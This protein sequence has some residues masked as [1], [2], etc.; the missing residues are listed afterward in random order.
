MDGSPTYIHDL[1]LGERNPS[2]PC[3]E[4]T[5]LD[6]GRLPSGAG[7]MLAKRSDLD[8][9]V[10]LGFTSEGFTV[11]SGSQT[12]GV[13]V[14]TL[15]PGALEDPRASFEGMLWEHLATSLRVVDPQDGPV[16]FIRTKTTVYRVP[17]RVGRFVRCTGPRFTPWRTPPTGLLVV[18]TRSVVFIPGHVYHVDPPVPPPPITGQGT[19]TALR[20]GDRG[21]YVG[22]WSPRQGVT[23]LFA[24][25]GRGGQG[26]L[27]SDARWL[28]RDNDE[29]TPALLEHY[30][31]LVR[32]LVAAP[33]GEAV[34]L[35]L[36]DDGVVVPHGT[37][38][39][40]LGVQPIVLLRPL[41]TCDGTASD[42][43]TFDS[44]VRMTGV[45]APSTAAV[46]AEWP[47]FFDAPHTLIPFDEDFDRG[48]IEGAVQLYHSVR[49]DREVL[50]DHPAEWLLGAVTHALTYSVT[51]GDPPQAD[52]VKLAKAPDPVRLVRAWLEAA[53]AVSSRDAAVVA[54]A[55]Y[56][57][58]CLH[59]R[60][61]DRL[62]GDAA[63]ILMASALHLV[64]ASAAT[65]RLEDAD[66]AS[67]RRHEAWLR[68]NLGN[69][70][71]ALGVSV[72]A[73]STEHFVKDPLAALAD[74]DE[75][76][77]RVRAL[78]CHAMI[79]A[80]VV[81]STSVSG[82]RVFALRP[83]FVVALDAPSVGALESAARQ[84]AWLGDKKSVDMLDRWANKNGYLQ[85]GLL[86]WKKR[87]VS[88]LAEHWHRVAAWLRASRTRPAETT[89]RLIEAHTR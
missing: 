51:R 6:I 67:Q 30:D 2:L 3:P 61:L 36:L 12:A 72:P 34:L 69:L 88:D 23:A 50:A 63:M 89:A 74:V 32:R 5:T 8:V 87:R 21:I 19:L 10:R 58:V 62:E 78:K 52:T 28:V 71:I 9:F 83:G 85:Q 82:G 43:A 57:M 15:D 1:S 22:S 25:D 55:L 11:D 70:C 77:H 84:R 59:N 46:D 29:G 37:S 49:N 56:M 75:K 65:L 39:H 42:A 14:F 48:A 66:V 4:G 68:T 73:A 86:G 79:H 18:L 80:T 38:A 44:V 40:T 54:S 26:Q 64:N 20:E 17:E 27:P 31:A 45:V 16:R 47:G 76:N 7:R 24:R 41:T 33:E 13:W 35:R 53:R 81:P 60:D